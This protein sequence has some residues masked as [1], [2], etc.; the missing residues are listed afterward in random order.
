MP[1]REQANKGI[2]AMYTWVLVSNPPI[3]YQAKA[4]AQIVRPMMTDPNILWIHIAYL[5]AEPFI[6]LK[7]ET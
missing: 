7:D 2:R 4:D 3:A 6:Y 1:T 5:N